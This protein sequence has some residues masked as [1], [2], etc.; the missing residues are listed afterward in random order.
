MFETAAARD[1]F[2][3][4]FAQ[5]AAESPGSQVIG[6]APVLQEPFDVVAVAEGGAGFAAGPGPV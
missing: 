6:S 3:A 1:A 2:A 4:S 5:T